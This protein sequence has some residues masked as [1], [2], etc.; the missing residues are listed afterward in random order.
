MDRV[1][2]RGGRERGILVRQA[3][4]RRGRSSSLQRADQCGEDETHPDQPETFKGCPETSSSP[5]FPS[6][7]ATPLHGQQQPRHCTEQEKTDARPD[8][9]SYAA[10]NPRGE[11]DGVR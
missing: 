10:R 11:P 2:L 7:L 1:E 3:E 6:P 9:R 5:F 4:V 8:D